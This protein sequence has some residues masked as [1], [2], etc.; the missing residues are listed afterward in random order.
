[1]PYESGIN[2]ERG[3]VYE[4]TSRED[5]ITYQSMRARYVLSAA[6]VAHACAFEASSTTM[7]IESVRIGAGQEETRVLFV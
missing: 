7:T 2:L 3:H 5:C 6:S 4:K 1:M